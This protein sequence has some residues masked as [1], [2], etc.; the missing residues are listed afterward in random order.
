MN[1]EVFVVEEPATHE[2]SVTSSKV[3]E[4][5]E[6][7]QKEDSFSYFHTPACPLRRIN[8]LQTSPLN[9]LEGGRNYAE[10]SVSN[11]HVPQLSLLHLQPSRSVLPTRG[12]LSQPAP[13]RGCNCGMIAIGRGH[14]CNPNF[15]KWHLGY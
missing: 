13:G 9:D 3:A 4:Y 12:A 8:F 5:L 6:Q 11:V 14:G 15:P 7:A 1:S 2:E 10:P